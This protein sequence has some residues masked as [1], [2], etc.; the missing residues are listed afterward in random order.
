MRIDDPLL[1]GGGQAAGLLTRTRFAW[2]AI[3]ALQE[4]VE[5]GRAASTSIDAQQT[6]RS[7]LL[8]QFQSHFGGFDQFLQ[9][10]VQ[11]AVASKKSIHHDFL[12]ARGQNPSQLSPTSIALLA[13]KVAFTGKLGFLATHPAA[14]INV[15]DLPV[16]LIVVPSTSTVLTVDAV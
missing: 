7:L 13:S 2:H 15:Q 16:G 4:P 10:G 11:L 14:Q 6:V 9:R 3:A 1:H 5:I 12:V 8:S